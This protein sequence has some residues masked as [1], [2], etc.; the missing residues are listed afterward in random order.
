MV[1]VFGIFTG[2]FCKLFICESRSNWHWSELHDDLVKASFVSLHWAL[3]QLQLVQASFHGYVFGLKPSVHALMARYMFKPPFI[4]SLFW[5]DPWKLI[6]P[7]Y[8]CP[9]GQL[10]VFKLVV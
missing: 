4:G 7:G 1:F 3:V 8:K 9:S 2:K 6:A 10:I 5:S